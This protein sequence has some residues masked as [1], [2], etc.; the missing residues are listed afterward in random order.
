ME[1]SHPRVIV[2]TWRTCKIF[3]ESVLSSLL[4]SPTGSSWQQ[5]LQGQADSETI[6]ISLRG[7]FQIQTQIQTWTRTAEIVQVVWVRNALSLSLVHTLSPRATHT[8]LLCV[9]MWIMNGPID[10]PHGPNSSLEN[11][12]LSPMPLTLSLSLSQYLY[13]SN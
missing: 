8:L 4:E 13:H 12:P 2:S 6:V 5:E 1:R 9:F 3:W 7:W 11:G 10:G